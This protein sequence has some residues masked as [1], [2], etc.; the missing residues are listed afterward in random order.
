[1]KIEEL[2]PL[3]K[4]K[5]NTQVAHNRTV[6]FCSMD[7]DMLRF[8]RPPR[9]KVARNRPG[10]QI[11]PVQTTFSQ[12]QV[13]PGSRIQKHP[14]TLHITNL[15]CSKD[16]IW[17]LRPYFVDSYSRETPPC[18]L[19]EGELGMALDCATTSRIEADV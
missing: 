6:G 8:K 13:P 2:V 16:E 15:R 18:R 4:S 5:K 9:A 7:E 14:T 11:C 12:S 1:M 3:T 19:Q 17:A 10:P